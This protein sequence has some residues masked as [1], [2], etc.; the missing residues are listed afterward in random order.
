MGK[1]DYVAAFASD[2]ALLTKLALAQLWFMVGPQ[3][4]EM[5]DRLKIESNFIDGLR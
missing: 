3:I 5:L 1:S 2:I 4:G